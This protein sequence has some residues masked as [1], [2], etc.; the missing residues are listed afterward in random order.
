[1][2][3]NQ[4]VRTYS[5]PPR[6]PDSWR[7]D[8]PADFAEDQ[9]QPT[10]DLLGSQGPDQGYALRLAR[11]L[12]PELALTE[13]EHAKDALAGIVAVGLKRASALGRAPVIH[14]LRI[15]ATIF[16]FLDPSPDHELV[17]LRHELFEEVSHFHHYMELR[18]LVDMVPVEVLRQTPDQVTD[19]H[20]RGWRD[21]LDLEPASAG[22]AARD[23]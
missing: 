20:R 15:A 7:A 11:V 10:G 1:M 17:A 4:D 5:S 6:R 3:P 14:D 23:A 9:R 12:E 22:H 2:D 19:A 8:R 18:R 21:L 16:G 13:G